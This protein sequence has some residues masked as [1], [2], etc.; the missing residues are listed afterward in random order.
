MACGWRPSAA[1]H[2]SPGVVGPLGQRPGDANQDGILDLSDAVRLLSH[3]FRGVPQALPCEGG[4]VFDSGNVS[5]LDSSGDGLV[6]L[7]DAVS[8]LG[9]L[10]RRGPAPILGTRCVEIPGCP[11]VCR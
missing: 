2:G 5:L 7:T 8:V 4:T 6:N 11:D 1:L 3:L 9:F 10:F